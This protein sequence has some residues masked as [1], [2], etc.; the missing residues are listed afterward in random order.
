MVKAAALARALLFRIKGL[1]VDMEGTVVI[2]VLVRQAAALIHLI[3]RHLIGAAA[4]AQDWVHISVVRKA[5]ER[6]GSRSAAKSL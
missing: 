5:A 2:P 1:V 3:L 4:V 6:S